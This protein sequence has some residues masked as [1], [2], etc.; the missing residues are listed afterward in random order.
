[1]LAESVKRRDEVIATRAL[2]PAKLER[3]AHIAHRPG[4]RDAKLARRAI[5]QRGEVLPRRQSARLL[6]TDAEHVAREVDHL[7]AAPCGAEKLHAGFGQLMC[8]V[9]Y[10][11]VDA[12]EQLGHAAVAQR[13]VGKEKM[14]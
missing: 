1:R 7:A 6:Q 11:D 9:E 8:L 14:V 3:A 13:H 10:R 12:R 5:A 2:V 4:A